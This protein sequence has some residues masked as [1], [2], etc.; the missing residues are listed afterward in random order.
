MKC[1]FLGYNEKQTKL[2]NFLRKKNIFVENKKGKISLDKIKK[3]DFIISFGYKKIIDKKIINNISRPIINLHMSYLPHNRGSHPNFWSFINNTVKGV[4]I[5]E[6]DKGLDSGPIIFQKKIT[7]NLKTNKNLTFKQ[8]Y[9]TL[10]KKL[11]IVFIKNYKKII[12]RKYR[13]KTNNIL[14]GSI[15]KKKDLPKDLKNWNTKI[16]KYL[17]N[18]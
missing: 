3:Y 11:E 15:H 14:K 8:T 17:I 12:F 2:I 6:I 4:T 16:L 13:V 9:K 5:H 10:F 7:F 1:L 18:R